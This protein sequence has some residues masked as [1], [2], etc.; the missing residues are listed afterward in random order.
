M[1][2]SWITEALLTHLAKFKRTTGLEHP[3]SIVTGHLTES[4]KVRLT[5][6][7]TPTVLTLVL[8]TVSCI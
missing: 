1:L 2:R 3:N 7:N 4:P 6:L 8:A 5:L